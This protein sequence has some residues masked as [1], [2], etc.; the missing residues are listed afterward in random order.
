[1]RYLLCIVLM[2]GGVQLLLSQIPITIPCSPSF[3]T[4]NLSG[5]TWVLTPN[6]D[7]YQAGALWVQWNHLVLLAKV[8]RSR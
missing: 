2:I 3:K 8:F 1:M 5:G 7:Q 4:A 6:E